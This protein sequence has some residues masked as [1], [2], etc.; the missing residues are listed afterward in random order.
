MVYAEVEEVR[1]SITTLN[2]GHSGS[3]TVLPLSTQPQTRYDFIAT[4]H[5]NLESSLIMLNERGTGFGENLLIHLYLS[6]L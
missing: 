2:E 5:G 3:K 1:L 6:N 4:V